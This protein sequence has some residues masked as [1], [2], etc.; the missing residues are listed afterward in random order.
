MA[1]NEVLMDKLADRAKEAAVHVHASTSKTKEKLESQVFEARAAADKTTKELQS[2]RADTNDEAAK[3]WS[4]ITMKWNDHIAQIQQKV[5][6][7]KHDRDAGRAR[8][9][10]DLA[11]DDAVMAIDFAYGAVEDAEWAVLD[12]ALA[13][14]EADELAAVKV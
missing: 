10:A 14:A 9:R 8:F 7:E 3:R 12:A 13:R 4:A 5:D 1:E 11:E 2:K 6:A